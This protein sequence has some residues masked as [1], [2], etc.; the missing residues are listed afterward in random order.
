MIEFRNV[1]FK[2]SENSIKNFNQT[3]KESEK[4]LFK[5]KSGIGKSSLIKAILGFAK[6]EG[7]IL[8]KG[9]V[10]TSKNVWDIRKQIGYVSQDNEIGEGTVRE[11]TDDIFLF[12]TNREFKKQNQNKIRELFEYFELDF[13][14]YTKN[15][16]ELSG[17]EK[18]R[19]S[20]LISILLDREIYLL[21][22]ITASL[23]ID[24]KEKV[25]KHFERIPATV[26]S[27][28]HDPQWAKAF[29][30]VTI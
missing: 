24:L 13:A 8:Y 1:S 16:S 25:V 26:I 27:I 6:Y 15:Y 18:Q 17:G 3:I 7:D 22:E 29:K 12:K 19:I 21:D 2:F 30:E 9:S 14:I 10:I 11:I 4:I 20:I 28:S 5:G 23:D